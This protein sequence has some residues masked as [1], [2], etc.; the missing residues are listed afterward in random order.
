MIQDIAPHVFHNA[1]AQKRSIQRGD[2]ILCFDQNQILLYKNKNG[3][4]DFLGF[5]AS[6]ATGLFYY[7]FSVDQTAY[8]LLDRQYLTNK[9][10]MKCTFLPI[11]IFREFSSASGFPMI[12]MTGYHIYHWLRKNRFCGCCGHK[13]EYFASERAVYCPQCH[14]IIYPQIAPAVAVAILNGDKILLAK[15][16]QGNFRRFSLIAGYVEVGETIEQTVHREVKEEVGLEVKNLR[17]FQSQPWGLTGIEMLGFF[18][19]LAGSN[20]ITLQKNELAEARWFS[21]HEIEPDLSLHS[22]S[23][24]MIETFRKKYE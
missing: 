20:K 4:Y 16:A 6:I 15:S 21:A 1:Y 13:T 17:Y 3:E 8:F 7:L 24:T 11:Q 18:V 10:M 23:Y 14:N 9:I 5:D 2:K 12:I 19:D 22:L